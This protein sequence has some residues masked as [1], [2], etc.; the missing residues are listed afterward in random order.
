MI[1]KLANLLSPSGII[2]FVESKGTQ[3]VLTEY[4]FLEEINKYKPYIKFW[5]KFWDIVKSEGYL[6][7]RELT[8][9]NLNALK[10]YIKVFHNELELMGTNNLSISEEKEFTLVEIQEW[11]EAGL[12]GF[13]RGSLSK[14][15]F[16]N[17]VL[18][19]VLSQINKDKLPKKFKTLRKFE[20]I[21]YKKNGKK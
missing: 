16:R 4:P 1:D 5:Q 18:S 2:I 15:E 17:K 7:Y 8:D 3:Q 21:L 10:N 11:I 20:F 13:Y 9:S 14:K 6:S 12:L 19:N